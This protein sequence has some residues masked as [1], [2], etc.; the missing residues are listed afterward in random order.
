MGKGWNTLLDTLTSLTEQDLLRTIYI[1]GEGHTV[2]DA[3]E[4]QLSHYSYHIGQ[5]VF[6]GKL[7]RGEQ[8]NS[9]SI[10]KGKSKEYLMEMLEKHQGK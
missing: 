9:L 8:W 4:R 3:I 7:V 1:R 6:I 10:P 2:I 5:I